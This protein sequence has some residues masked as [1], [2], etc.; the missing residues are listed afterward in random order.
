M[1]S[2]EL[3]Q[4]LD[5]APLVAAD[6]TPVP[7]GKGVVYSVVAFLIA[8]ATAAVG[9]V[10][11]RQR[12]GNALEDASNNITV[13]T[14]TSA[15][16]RIKELEDQVRSLLVDIVNTTNAQLEVARAASAAESKANQAAALAEDAQR[17]SA[18]AQRV[19]AWQSAYIGKLKAAMIA[20]GLTP[21]EPD[22]EP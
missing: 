21:P 17:D 2:V 3:E 5:N 18:R 6:G 9:W 16:I 14:L 1:Q 19:S 8:I 22:P 7:E 15:R 4:V 12:G 13:E 10:I 20:A 11:K